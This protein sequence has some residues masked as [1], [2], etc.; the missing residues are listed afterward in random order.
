MDDAHAAQAGAR[1][2]AQ[3]VGDA[4]ARLVAA[5]AVQVD[6]VLQHPDAAAQLADDVEAD[7]AAAKR[8]RVVG[9]EQRLDV[10]RVGDRLGQRRGLVALRAGAASAGGRAARQ[11]RRRALAQRH[12]RA[13]GAREQLLLAPLGERRARARRPRAPR[14]RGAARAAPRGSPPGRRG[15]RPWSAPSQ[16]APLGERHDLRPGRRRGGRGR[17]RRPAP[18]RSSASGSGTRR[19]ATARRRPTDGCAP[20]SPPPAPSS[21]ARLTTSRG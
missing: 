2:V 4:L 6:L 18:A 15:G 12:D 8:E 9:L 14:P 11:R 19:R 17:A 1:R 5:Q 20:G 7:A 16:Q 21:S 3:E 10:E 13:D